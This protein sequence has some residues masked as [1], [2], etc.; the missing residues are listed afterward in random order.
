MILWKKNQNKPANSSSS[1]DVCGAFSLPASEESN[2]SLELERLREDEGWFFE[3]EVDG[4][5]TELCEVDDN[6]RA[7]R[8][9]SKDWT[10]IEGA[11]PSRDWGWVDVDS[12]FAE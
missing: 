9:L 3:A 8:G 6:F 5:E 12:F 2:L 10:N 1:W 7:A 4:L 11:G